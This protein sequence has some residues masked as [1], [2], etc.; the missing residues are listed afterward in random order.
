MSAAFAHAATGLDDFFAKWRHP[1]K[2]AQRFS[3]KIGLMDVPGAPGYALVR[4]DAFP[5]GQVEWFWM[6]DLRADGAGFSAQIGNDAEELHN[7]SF[8]Q[9]IRFTRQDIGDWTYFQNGKIIGNATACPALA[10]ASAEERR[11]MKEQY[12]LNCD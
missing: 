4:P 2:G 5:A 7:V 12:G 3:V 10:H 11:Q 9:T 6:H 1:P 8:G